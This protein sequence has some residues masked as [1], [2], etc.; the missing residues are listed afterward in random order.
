[1]ALTLTEQIVVG[2]VCAVFGFAALIVA[3]FVV[4][5]QL[6]RNKKRKTATPSGGTFTAIQESH[7]MSAGSLGVFAP[8][9]HQHQHHHHRQHTPSDAHQK[10]QSTNQY[11]SFLAIKPS[12]EADNPISD[13]DNRRSLM[14]KSASSRRRHLRERPAAPLPTEAT[15]TTTTTTTTAAP[16]ARR[17]S[18]RSRPPAPLPATSSYGPAP[19]PDAAQSGAYGPA[20]P[21]IVE[22]VVRRSSSRRDKT[23]ERGQR[24]KRS[25]RHAHGE[26]ASDAH[27]AHSIVAPPSGK[28]L[29]AE[30]TVLAA[31]ET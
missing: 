2:I 15:T 4:R 10:R 18:K 20:P 6:A 1:M 19:A 17:S 9:Q 14:L 21:E 23:L 3:V 27:H 12:T 30:L 28:R 11:Q 26:T 7:P 31:D 5:C 8:A 29:S 16:V 24:S 22:P 13:R 25:R